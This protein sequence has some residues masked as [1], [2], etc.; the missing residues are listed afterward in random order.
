M[1]DGPELCVRCQGRGKV[2][3]IRTTYTCPVCLGMK[4]YAR[5]RRHPPSEHH[6]IAI[7]ADVDPW[8]A[9]DKLPIKEEPND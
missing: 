9:I 1:S 6:M 2:D 3:G 5:G 7:H 4:A 8:E